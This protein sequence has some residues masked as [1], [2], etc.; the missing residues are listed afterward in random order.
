[1][2][3]RRDGVA[4]YDAAVHPN[5]GREGTHH[6][7]LRVL[8]NRTVN[9][10]REVMDGVVGA[11]YK[12]TRDG[13]FAAVVEC[14]FERAVRSMAVFGADYVPSVGR[15]QEI[16]FV[17][18]QHRAEVVGASARELRV[19]AAQKAVVEGGAEVQHRRHT[20]AGLEQCP[21]GRGWPYDGDGVRPHK[22]RRLGACDLH[23]REHSRGRW[24]RNLQYQLCGALRH[25]ALLHEDRLCGVEEGHRHVHGPYRRR[26]LQELINDLNVDCDNV[27]GVGDAGG[28]VCYEAWLGRHRQPTHVHHVRLAPQRSH[29]VDVLTGHDVAVAT[30]TFI[31]LAAPEGQVLA[32]VDRAG[33]ILSRAT[34]VGVAA[35]GHG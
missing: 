4:E 32:A 28:V 23:V 17:A 2:P 34:V 18:Q 35:N 15:P 1:M 30:A 19:S 3:E 11:R 9:G 27:V 31:H 16:G 8:L 14:P 24:H 6:G 7:H 26:R 25:D 12:R 20:V 13:G 29:F 21:G 22:H 33:P 5:V 10:K